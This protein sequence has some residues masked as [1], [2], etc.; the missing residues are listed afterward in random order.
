MLAHRDPFLH[1]RLATSKWSRAVGIVTAPACMVCVHEPQ[2]SRAICHRRWVLEQV[3]PSIKLRLHP[4]LSALH[5][6]P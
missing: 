3:D 5:P 6:S 1:S 4:E 2:L